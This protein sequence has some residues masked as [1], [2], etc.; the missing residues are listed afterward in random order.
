[1]VGLHPSVARPEPFEQGLYS[2]AM[3]RRTYAL[4]RQQATEWL[5]RGRG[6][7][8]DATYGDRHERAALRRLAARLGR[9]LDVLV[10]RAPDE[11]LRGRLATR[12]PVGGIV[13][14]ARPTLWPELVGGYRP[15]SE[16]GEATTVDT[17]DG[18]AEA[19][20]AALAALRRDA[21]PIEEVPA[22]RRR[23]TASAGIDGRAPRRSSR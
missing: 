20:R 13:S 9:R 6:V 5:R 8:L 3:T 1:M 15:P 21:G 10:C 4:L 14:D 17:T 11:I 23:A 18:P 22:A 19:V 12:G 16:V 2:R 7:V